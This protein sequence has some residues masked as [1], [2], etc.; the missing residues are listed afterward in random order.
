MTAT[1]KQAAYEQALHPPRK[2][3]TADE[4]DQ[5]IYDAVARDKSIS[6]EAIVRWA[7]RTYEIIALTEAEAAGRVSTPD[8]N[9]HGMT[10]IAG[11]GERAGLNE[12]SG[13]SSEKRS[14]RPTGSRPSFSQ[15]CADH[16][17]HQQ[18]G[19]IT[20][21]YYAELSALGPIGLVALN[22]FR[23]QKRSSRAKD[24]RRGKW[25]RA[26]YD[27]KSWSMDEL[28]RI[29]AI[30]TNQARICS[31]ANL[32]SSSA[33]KKTPGLC[34]AAIRRSCSTSSFRKAR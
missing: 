1:S 13:C 26:A 23:A 25:R 4:F 29:L 7:H 34:S 21:A 19:R 31:C 20:K 10:G 18:D 5:I 17:F 32:A 12:H 30:T 9:T 15:K 24:Y 27:V 28:C 33:G 8:P 16:V 6:R 22:L 14:P 3:V 2:P 11:Q